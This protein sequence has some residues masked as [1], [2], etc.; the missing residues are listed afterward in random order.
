[1]PKQ[2]YKIENFHGGLSSN[3]DPRDIA[4]NEL[5]EAQDVMVDELGKIR[6]MGGAAPHGTIDAG[7]A[8]INPG[9]GLFQFSSD[10]T[11]ANVLLADYSGTHTDGNHSTIMT[12]SAAG[13]PVDALIGATINNYTDNGSSGVITDND[14]TTVTVSS[15]SGGS[16]NIWQTSDVYT[17]TNIPKTGDDYLALADTDGAANIDIW[18]RT[19]DNWGAGVIDLGS[20]TG[21]KPC[22]YYVDGALRVS[23]GSFAANDNQWYGYVYSKLYQTTAGAQEHLIDQWISTD[24]ELKSLDDLSVALVLDDCSTANPNTTSVTGSNRIVI[25]WWPGDDGT[26]NGRYYIGISPVYIGNQEGPISI[27]DQFINAGGSLVD[28]DGTIM[29]NN[30]KLNLQL[31]ICQS[32]SATVADNAAHLLVDSRIIGLKLYTRPY[33]SEKWYLM[34]NIDLQKGGKHGWSDYNAADTATGYLAGTTY[35]RF[36]NDTPGSSEVTMIRSGVSTV[37]GITDNSDHTEDTYTDVEFVGGTGSGAKATI[38][39]DSDGEIQTLTITAPGAGYTENDVLSIPTATIGG[40]GSPH[41]DVN[42]LNYLQEYS[43]CTANFEVDLGSAALGTNSDGT[44]RTGALRINGFQ[45]SPLYVEINLNDAN[46]QALTI[47]NAILPST[48]DTTF[49]FD[50]PDEQWNSIFNYSQVL[51]VEVYAGAPPPEE[52][53]DEDYGGS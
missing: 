28:H 49:T 40:S 19:T 20:A 14:A 26:W 24:Q 48:G 6:T 43:V 33:S 21:M 29:L 5:S 30:E 45:N 22:F 47:T 38:I 41:C 15:L 7:A 53:E 23:D 25:G 11:A 34:K 17:I 31:F 39:I 37:D 46:E 36:N 13:F 1:M 51:K 3:S 44:N 10:R 8:A 27:P 16:S 4:D 9:Y 42:A 12:D 52:Q 32:T 35:A 50:I 18:S 2:T